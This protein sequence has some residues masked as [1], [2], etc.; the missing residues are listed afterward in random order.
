MLPIGK[1]INFLSKK[2]GVSILH[3]LSD[4]VGLS[5]REFLQLKI[6]FSLCLKIFK[7]GKIQEIIYPPPKKINIKNL[8]RKKGCYLRKI[9]IAF[10]SQNANKNW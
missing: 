8:G 7:I 5:N 10:L 3:L 2:Q 1:K 6:C 4:Y 9:V